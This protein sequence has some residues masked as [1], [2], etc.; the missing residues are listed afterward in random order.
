[1]IGAVKFIAGGWAIDLLIG[2][3]TREHKDIAIFRKDQLNLKAY[4][5][6]MGF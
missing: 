2:K 3:E 1:M 6:R 5:K 4:L